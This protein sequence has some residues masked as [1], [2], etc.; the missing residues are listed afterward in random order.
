MRL[1]KKLKIFLVLFLITSIASPAVAKPTLRGKYIQ[2]EKGEAIPW[3]GW[4]FDSQAVAEI[5]A[6]KSLEEDRCTLRINQ[7]LEEQR[8]RL[9]LRYG[10]LEA[11]L[12]YEM[13]TKQAA[14]DALE[15]E[16]K[17][18]EKAI[19]NS[20]KYGWIAPLALG[21]L[22]GFGIGALVF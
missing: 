2:L 19:I 10:K 8:A 6:N 22:A 16:N 18:L 5:L 12:D 3:L 21:I 7:N 1:M 9:D 4:C 11:R 20:S 14:I 13:N 17:K 15:T